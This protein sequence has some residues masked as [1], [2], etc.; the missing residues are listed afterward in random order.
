MGP[1][2]AAED[3]ARWGS[4][5]GDEV[6]R[7]DNERAGHTLCGGCGGTGNELY[8]MYRPCSDCGGG[9]IAVKWGELSRLGRRLAERKERRERKELERQYR[10]PR[11]WGLEIRWR[12]SRWFGI[13]QCFGGAET[14]HRCQ[15]TASDIDYEVRRVRPFRVECL[16]REMCDEMKT[17]WSR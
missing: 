4:R 6:R 11:D 3:L 17:E 15:V 16:D 13:G 14:C 2:I 9:G 12:I 8:A 10:A 1:L 7:R 5:A